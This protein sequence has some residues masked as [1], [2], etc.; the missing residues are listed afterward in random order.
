MAPFHHLTG[1]S[2]GPTFATDV[3]L[4][5]YQTNTVQYVCSIEI[6]MVKKY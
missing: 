5:T 4:G 2:A 6:D 1:P 3:L